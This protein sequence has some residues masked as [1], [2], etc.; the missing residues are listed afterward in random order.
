MYVPPMVPFLGTIGALRP[1]PP[2]HG[3]AEVQLHDLSTPCRLPPE[4]ALGMASRLRTPGRR[5]RVQRLIQLA[6]LAAIAVVCAPR[7]AFAQDSATLRPTLRLDT[8]R[9]V[10][11]ADVAEL[12]GEEAAKL[13]GVVVV[14]EKLI[15]TTGSTIDAARIREAAG[16]AGAR[17]GNVL[18]SGPACSVSVDSKART[19]RSSSKPSDTP[20]APDSVRARVVTW[21][22]QEFGVSQNDLRLTFEKGRDALLET[23]TT[24]RTVAIKSQGS[25]DRMP[26]SIRVFEGGT[27][28]VEG[29]VR[30]EVLIRRAAPIAKSGLERGTPIKAGEVVVQDRWLPPSVS[31]ADAKDVAGSAATG[32]VS[33]G[34]VIERGRVAPVLA[35]EKGD[36]LAVD[37]V[38]STLV[39]RMNNAR[40]LEGGREGDVILVEAPS[41][42]ATK[43]GKGKPKMT[44]FRAKISGPGRAVA[45]NDGVGGGA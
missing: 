42:L 14:S 4:E 30:V 45:I 1:S 7:A 44:T 11:V 29:T 32:R 23:T 35:V 6:L 26:I 19:T 25:S 31:P 28:I 41:T 27:L 12:R 39:V 9:D 38:T 13:A 20:I 43:A 3:R 16:K 36:V 37:A 5:S 15:G 40:A 21:V 33:A 8:P 22:A 34:G 2:H 10:T 17:V 18:I 24:G